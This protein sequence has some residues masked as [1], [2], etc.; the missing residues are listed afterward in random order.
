MLLFKKCLNYCIKDKEKYEKILKSKTNPKKS[1]KEPPETNTQT[2]PKNKLADGKKPIEI[3]MV[4]MDQFEPMPDQ[5]TK[6]KSV[7][8]PP[9][10][11]VMNRFEKRLGIIQSISV[12]AKKITA[13][14][15]NAE[16]KIA[17]L[18]EKVDL[19]SLRA[20][21][22]LSV[23]RE[24]D[25]LGCDKLSE[26]LNKL[27]EQA[28]LDLRDAEVRIKECPKNKSKKGP[29]GGRT[30]A[31]DS[32]K[33]AKGKVV[34]G[35]GSTTIKKKKDDDDSSEDDSSEEPSEKDDDY[36]LIRCNSCNTELINERERCGV[37]EIEEAGCIHCCKKCEICGECNF[38]I[39]MIEA[40]DSKFVCCR[41][42]SITYEER[43]Q[44]QAER[45]RKEE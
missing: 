3:E 32:A 45:A 29:A 18:R 44:A 40:S 16:K 39:K 30:G 5:R 43:L 24:Y 9:E 22:S 6:I 7:K 15:E 37:G 1:V 28:L 35:K 17:E 8:F 25:V 12:V 23:L 41:E 36:D 2:I 42:C 11:E 33:Q 19:I 14:Q 10:V 13:D 20:D 4:E 21:K 27:K 31:T 26:K 38:N 34:K